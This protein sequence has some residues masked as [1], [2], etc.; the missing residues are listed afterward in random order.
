MHY[1][2]LTCPSMP[3]GQL[4]LLLRDQSP[5]FKKAGADRHNCRSEILAVDECSRTAHIS[6]VVQTSKQAAR[7]AGEP[8]ENLHSQEG[9][10]HIA[11]QRNSIS[12]CKDSGNVTWYEF[13][14]NEN[15]EEEDLGEKVEKCTRVKRKL[16][17]LRSRVT[18][19]FNKDKGKSRE[20]EQQR[21]RGKEVKEHQRSSSI[22]SSNGHDL[23]PGAFSSCATCS[24]CSKSL[25]KKHGLQC[26]NCA[27]NVHKT[28]KS[29]LTE[30]TSN[31][32]D[33]L[34]RTG[35][36]VS[37]HLAI[38]DRERESLSSQAPDGHSTY[39]SV[40]GMTI[41]PRGGHTQAAAAHSTSS[42][43]AST[44]PMASLR[45]HS[46]S[47]SLPGDMDEMDSLRSKR[48]NEDV[49]SLAPST[50]ESIIVEDAHYAAVRADLESDAQDL[51]A[52]SWSLAVD[53]QFV[54][55][56]SKDIV[57]RQDIIYEL[58][59]TEMHHVRTLK[60]MLR[61][62]VR[63][64]KESL[65]MDSG[66][67][68][69]LFPRL[70][71]LLEL[72]T[73]FLSRLKERRRENLEA[74]SD[75]NF[76]IHRVADILIAQFSG[77]IG[78]KMKDGYG[79]FCSHHSEA[80]GYY[81]EQ[82]QNNKK[83]HSTIRKINNLSIVRRLGVTECI[84][85][86][87]QRITKYPVLVERILHHT[88]AG[89]QEYEDL[90]H[91]LT[92]IKHTIV[93]V[94]S[95]VN[96]HEK[97]TR[98]RDIYNKMEPKS[99]GKIK[100]GR[101]FRRE[102]LAQ[103]WRRLLHEGTVNWKA[104]S[105]RLK[106][107]LAVLLSDVLILI[108]EK[109]Q[110]YV[111]A[112]VDNKPSVISLQKLIVREVA[113]E[114][115]AM[116]LICASSDEPEMY[117]IHTSSKEERNIWMTHIRQAVESC[118]QTEERLF[119]EE[120]EARASRLKDFQERLSQKD[121]V[122]VQA[123]SE[124]LQM[125]A[126]IAESV[127]GVEDTAYRS[128]LLLR[129]DGTDLLQGETLL[130][131][132]ITEVENL[133]NLLQSGVKEESHR[134]E[135]ISGALPKRAVTFGGYD[136]TSAILHNN[137]TVKTGESKNRD[138]SQRAS[139]DPQLKDLCGSHTLEEMVDESCCSPPRWN[140]IWSDSFPEAEFFDRVLMLSQR[141]YSL[142][143]IISQQDSQIEMQRASLT[144][145]ASFP[146][147]YRG[148]CL[149]EQEKQRTLA[150][151]REE[152]ANFHKL[153][154]Q[155]R[156]EQQRW[157]K[158]REKHRHQVE[159][160]ESKLRQREEECKR[161]EERL[162]EEREEL[163]RQREK[164][165]EDLERLRESTRA[166]EKEKERLEHQ[167]KSKRKTIEVM[168]S[169]VPLSGSL[170]GVSSPTGLSELKGLRSSVSVAPADF[171]ERPEVTLRR[172][173]SSSTLKTEVPLHLLS[174]TNQHKSVSVSQ[175]IPTKL[176]ALSSV[177][178]SKPGKSGKASHRSDSSVS[179]DM[180]QML[181]LKLSARDDNSLKAKRSISPHQPLTVST[182]P[183][184]H[185]DS[186]SPPDSAGFESHSSSLLIAPPGNTHKP[187]LQPTISVQSRSSGSFLYQ[188]QQPTFASQPP[189]QPTVPPP[190]QGT[191]EDLKED[192][193]FF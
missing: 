126:E 120:E 178:G 77:E 101:V 124:K 8:E 51:E 140:R 145:R 148:N 177:K 192:V 103:G 121:A 150:L 104:A 169:V 15:E 130:K 190:Y 11:K 173:V 90:T 41:L 52:E 54:K 10:S 28:C 147:R 134:L 45:H 65:Q 168:T 129:G 105:G 98:L 61:V 50:V 3:L 165:Q 174:T 149:Q 12:D 26:M 62:Y 142:Q 191:T 84:L 70:E 43:T 151:Q 102:D 186:L 29:L 13:L 96:L 163:E 128:R 63:E 2:L 9:Q 162:A 57:K 46:S 27:V 166:V 44:I 24:L 19:S 68:D 116:F 30:C 164:Y 36:S 74:P 49:I 133:Q 184:P 60:I 83:F 76:I 114:E 91:A 157:E 25:Q 189:T 5:D 87:T 119:S 93:Q 171:P 85:L 143:A 167:K 71:N 59:Q 152:L 97:T 159:A 17:S 35:S 113:H 155:H 92:L 187:P 154:A 118:P 53:Q 4:L 21:E 75:R 108:Q 172:E 141:L 182:S 22:I 33:T 185:T 7:A 144:E 170:N 38:K 86:V 156:Q 112:A 94:D 79:D 123:L 111:F 181:P 81:K 18:G 132:A 106:D 117:E 47:G 153:Q 188:P 23:V 20:K 89:T 127:A 78:E 160:T 1:L 72:H 125:F 115:K 180:K 55:K 109:D 56:H 146:S 6:R 136:S 16:S 193:I 31:K 175:Q 40:P 139:S 14:S 183:L 99:Q 32:R 67:I 107:I 48:C 179:M 34:P 37:S 58:M 131:G 73:Y 69:C 138:R 64:L 39:P 161:L 176:A 137:G 95:L 110:R 122:I 158:E 100:D 135:E 66:R 42:S 82:L 88:E 80:V